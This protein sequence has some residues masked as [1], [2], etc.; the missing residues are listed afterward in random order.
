MKQFGIDSEKCEK[1]YGEGEGDDWITSLAIC[2]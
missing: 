1:D 2:P